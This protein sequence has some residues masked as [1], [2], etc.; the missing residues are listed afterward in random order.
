MVSTGEKMGY[1]L[2]KIGLEGDFG[3]TGRP[4]GV[5]AG[6]TGLDASRGGTYLSTSRHTDTIVKADNVPTLTWPKKKPEE[7]IKTCNTKKS[8]HRKVRMAVVLTIPESWSTSIRNAM[9]AAMTPVSTVPLT[10][11]AVLGCTE[12]KKGG[13]KPSRAMA[14]RILGWPPTEESGGK[15]SSTDLHKEHYTKH[16]TKHKWNNIQNPS[17]IFA[18]QSHAHNIIILC[19]KNCRDVNQKD[20]LNF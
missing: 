11:T 12:E 17:K 13:S 15:W 1:W 6:I 10:G 5:R 19:L 20:N 14:I 4:S 16:Y 2:V 8:H 9:S 3:T 7:K 18:S